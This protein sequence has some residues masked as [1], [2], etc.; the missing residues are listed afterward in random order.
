MNHEPDLDRRFYDELWPHRAVV[1]RMALFLC[2]NSADADD[3]AQEAMLR[4]YRALEKFEAES[5]DEARAWLIAILRNAWIDRTRSP[6]HK[7]AGLGLDDL[8]EDP[9]DERN[10]EADSVW[11]GPEDLLERFG[12]AEVIAALRSLPEQ[13][14][15]TLLLTDVE[16]LDHEQAAEVLGVPVGT[17]KS[18]ASR[19]RGALRDAL[20]PVAK[21]MGLLGKRGT[22]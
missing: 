7:R 2:H 22:P 11:D 12:D 3:L 10:A 14:R 1:L 5:A 19:A 4:G 20:V 13:A 16:G 17:I 6:G 9:A 18:R 8:P 15:W 21:R